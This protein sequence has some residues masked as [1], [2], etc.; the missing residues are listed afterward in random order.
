MSQNPTAEN[1]GG[2]SAFIP[3]CLWALFV[4][5]FYFSFKTHPLFRVLPFWGRV[6][7][8]DSFPPPNPS[9]FW[10]IEAGSARIFLTAFVIMGATWALGRRLRYW[11]GLDLVD[12][13]VR[14]AFDFG[15]G[16]CGLNLFW[17]GT[18]L[19]GLWFKPIWITAGI[20]LLVSLASECA[21]LFKQK[22]GKSLAGNFPT[23]GYF[24]LLL[25]GIFYWFFSLLQNLAPETFYDSMVYHL[26]VPQDW[27]FHH[28]IMD[29]PSN[30]FANYPYGAEI[31]FLNGLVFQGTE[32]AKML[33][34][35]AFGACALLAGG[36]AR[37]I[38]GPRA[39]WLALALT[40][41][42][43]LFAVNLWTTQVEG[44]LSLTVLVFIYALNRFVRKEGNRWVWAVLAG[45]FL[46]LALSTKYTAFLAAGSAL[47]VLAFQNPAI[48]KKENLKFWVVLSIGSLLMLG[49]WLIKNLVFTGNPFFPYLMSYFPGRHLPPGG[50][51]RLLQEQHARVTTDVGS[52]LLLP[53]TLTMANPDSYNFCGPLCL[54]L[55]PFLFLFRLRHPSLRFLAGTSLIFM[56]AG[57]AVTHILRFVLPDFV[58]L[59]ILL[60]AVLAG[61]SKPEWGKGAAW[62]AGL[63]AI[64][65]FGY[66]GAI[67]HYY[68]SAGGIW[69][70]RQTRDSYLM[71]Q[72]KITPYISMAR[73]IS[74]HTPADSRL[75]IAGDARGLYYDR[76]FL[77]NTVF[78]AQTL[79]QCAK[80]EKDAEGIGKRL[81]EMGVDYL[82]VNG[83]EGI[84][85]SA[86]YHHYDLSPEE[87]KRLDDFIQRGTEAVYFENFQGVYR[88]LPGLKKS[89]SSEI[90]DILLCF[91]Q[92]ASEFIKNLRGQKIREAEESLNQVLKLYPFSKTWKKQQKEFEANFGKSLHG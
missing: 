87:W 22:V 79:A 50:Y 28:G 46:G 25:M 14:V 59:F 88:L 56:A 51:E 43:P 90:P 73:W 31:Y 53:W 84:R 3:L 49:P 2:S 18:G 72:G 9:D 40:L 10:N 16:L 37:E 86:D 7:D 27:L 38:A 68:Y 13:W 1:R 55:V 66:L 8:F 23:G 52:W 67:S 81:R 26:A 70:G 47:I 69:S 5:V 82:A 91:S 21:V 65:C 15:L 6:F 29:V 32:S 92:P 58:L 61:G 35:A 63:S 44:F 33:H 77:T 76:P 57:F 20:F 74:D 45:L 80:E 34:A 4:F 36:W 54:S 62:I 83:L 42:F 60:G 41:T 89:P 19:E 11:L 17:I 48:F 75:L 85:V 30:F 12:S 24:F 39:G 71:G 78:D 64:L